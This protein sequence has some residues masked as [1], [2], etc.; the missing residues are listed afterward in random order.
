M[1]HFQVFRRTE[2]K[3]F[4]VDRKVIRVE[5]K[6]KR[7][8]EKKESKRSEKKLEMNQQNKK[9]S[10]FWLMRMRETKIMYNFQQKLA[11]N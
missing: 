3:T 9:K 11:Q 6:E 5:D 10:K 8:G 7:K 2:A 4:Q 1:F